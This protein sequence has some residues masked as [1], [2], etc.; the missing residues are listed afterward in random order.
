[1]LRNHRQTFVWGGRDLVIVTG[2]KFAA[3]HELLKGACGPILGT[4]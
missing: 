3:F 4:D 2:R 1:M